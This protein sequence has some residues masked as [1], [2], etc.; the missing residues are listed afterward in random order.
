MFFLKHLNNF[1]IGLKLVLIGSM[2]VLNGSINS[3]QPALNTLLKPIILLDTKTGKLIIP[4]CFK[5]VKLDIGLSYNAPM[6]QQW[7]SHEQDLLVFGFEPNPAAVDLILQGAQKKEPQHG[8][9]LDPKFIGKNFFLIPCA[10]G[11]TGN[12]MAKFY[13]TSDDCG[14][15]SL[16]EPKGFGI[17]RVIDV[18][19][20][21]LADFFA[22]FPFNTH[23]VID[24]IKVD[25]QGSDLDIIKSAKHYLKEHVIYITIEAEN[26][27]Y[28][29]T[30]NSV[31]AI[32][33]YMREIGF[34]P[35]QEISQYMDGFE[36]LKTSSTCDPTYFNPKFSA[37]IKDHPVQ[38]YQRG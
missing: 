3:M 37:Y 17:E 1:I 9:P 2:L 30:N 33:K 38:I 12:C 21:T 18:P 7:L 31:S 10:L 35:I 29:Q 36:P 16:Y 15:S 27:L 20:F 32:N 25:A 24:Y 8:D 13:V 26:E 6:S 34:V 11:L 4:A 22:I 28:A 14:C 23:P 5:H 19:V